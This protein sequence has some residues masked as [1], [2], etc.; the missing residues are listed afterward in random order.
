MMLYLLLPR[1]PLDWDDI[2]V[3]TSFG[4]VERLVTPSSFVLALEGTDEL[5]PVWFYQL[6]KGLLRRYPLSRSPSGS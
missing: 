3:F 1:G 4:A 5:T 6:E 2:R